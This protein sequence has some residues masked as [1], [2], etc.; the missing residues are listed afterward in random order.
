MLRQTYRL[1][2]VVLV[3]LLKLSAWLQCK[4]SYLGSELQ[5][6]PADR[7]EI[8]SE[9]YR[10]TRTMFA[11]KRRQ[12][13]PSVCLRLFYLPAD[14]PSEDSPS[15]VL[16]LLQLGFNSDLT[17]QLSPFIIAQP[18]IDGGNH[19]ETH[20]G[21]REGITCWI[22]FPSAECRQQVFMSPSLFTSYD[23]SFD[24]NPL[25][26]RVRRHLPSLPPGG[27]IWF[28]EFTSRLTYSCQHTFTALIWT[29][30]AFLSFS[31]FVQQLM[32]SLPNERGCVRR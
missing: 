4:R 23:I 7:M 32:S 9:P 24:M 1:G 8:L 6:E 19:L 29:Q 22:T 26:C 17:H 16:S 15:C 10:F 25:T 18:L 30:V 2:V 3:K 21:S 27:R 5:T 11:A 20:T 31:F 13:S 28:P 14:V 12:N